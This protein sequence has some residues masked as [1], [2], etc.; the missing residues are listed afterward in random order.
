VPA[1]GYGMA[2]PHSPYRLFPPHPVF[3]Q[4]PSPIPSENLQNGHSGSGNGDQAEALK[5]QQVEAYLAA[6]SARQLDQLTARE[7][8]DTLKAQGLE[9]SERYVA[10]ILDQWNARRRGSGTPRKRGR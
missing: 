2:P 9:V 5:R 3:G 6:L 10:Q 7:I 1:P 4:M 8:T